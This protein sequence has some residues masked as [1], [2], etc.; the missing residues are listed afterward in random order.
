MS[1]DIS[2]LNTSNFAELAQAMGMEADT[3]TKKQTSTLAR[4]KIE[5]DPIMGEIEHKGK[6]TKVEV[7]EAGKY[8]LTLSDGTTKLYDTNPS[9]RVFTQKFMYKKYVKGK[10]P[11][12]KDTYIKTEMANNWKG[13]HRDTAGGFN[14]GKPSGWIDDY[15]SIPQEQKELIKSVKRVRVFFG[16]ITLTAPVNN[17][18]EST[19]TVT[20][21]VPF[22]YEIDNKE[23]FKIMGGPISEMLKQ[24][25]LFPQ[26]FLKLGTQERSIASGKKYFVPSVE[27]ESGV[28][29]LKNPEDTDTYKDFNEWISRYN[30]WVA[31]EYSKSTK[32]ADEKL[33]NEFVDIE[34]A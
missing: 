7:I 15:N 13:D 33:V 6:K 1:T 9:I 16:L 23:A 18:G 14:C 4:L 20:R 12:G 3:Q 11:N 27:L 34:A 24:K 28:V 22:I 17:K 19:K 25:Y 8:C 32:D 5:H 31:N 26:K 21:D 30:T 29:D 2:T 10:G